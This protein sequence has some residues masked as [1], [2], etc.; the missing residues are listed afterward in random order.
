MRRG[1]VPLWVISA[2]FITSVVRAQDTAEAIGPIPKEVVDYCQLLQNSQNLEQLHS[3]PLD[4]LKH[5][6]ATVFEANSAHPVALQRESHA[7]ENWQVNPT[8]FRLALN[9]AVKERI[10]RL[11][12][13]L[14]AVP[15]LLKA[16]IL[17]VETH[18][19]D[20]SGE[21][22]GVKLSMPITNITAI[23]QEVV[24]GA[25]RF[26]PGDSINFYFFPIWR[27]TTS[28]FQAGETD[29]LPLQPVLNQGQVSLSLVTDLDT[30]HAEYNAGEISK[31][32]YGRYPIVNGTVMDIGKTFGSVPSATWESF[33]S[34]LLREINLIKTW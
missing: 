20:L 12:F 13:A 7:R 30:T 33:K 27:P 21:P 25:S 32:G 28:Q 19:Y 29:F 6:A 15:Y 5:I 31:G 10:S 14:I 24:K 3:M 11:D 22:S 34:Y 18:P 23:V 17:K 16:R 1:Y 26:S 2:V 9:R 8:I 4:G